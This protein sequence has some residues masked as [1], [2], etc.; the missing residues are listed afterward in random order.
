MFLMSAAHL[1]TD[2]VELFV[3]CDVVCC[4]P[5]CK[6]VLCICDACVICCY[7]NNCNL[8][9]YKILLIYYMLTQF[10]YTMVV[11]HI[12]EAWV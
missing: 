3:L 4:S 6:V 9:M 1:H 12:Q 11:L 10:T 8:F 5:T 7:I 2:S